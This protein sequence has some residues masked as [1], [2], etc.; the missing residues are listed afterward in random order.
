MP[1]QTGHIEQEFKDQLNIYTSVQLHSIRKNKDTSN[2]D[3]IACSKIRE[4][5]IKRIFRGKRGGKYRYRPRIQPKIKA[6]T[7]YGSNHY[8]NTIQFTGKART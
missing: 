8:P 3:K 5:E 2:L 4:L 1:L 7:V 6:S